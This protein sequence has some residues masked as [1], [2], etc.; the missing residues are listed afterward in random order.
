MHIITL[1]LGAAGNKAVF[2][3]IQSGVIKEQD[4]VIE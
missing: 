2:E 1:G 3:A 4:T